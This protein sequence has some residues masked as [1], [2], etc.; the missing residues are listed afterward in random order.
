VCGGAIVEEDAMTRE[1]DIRLRDAVLRQLDWDPEID[2][3]GLAVAAQNG[4]VMLTGYVDSAPG[5]LAAE[6]A[7][8]QVEGVRAVVNQ[9]E[10]RL[11]SE[12]TDADIAKE[13]ARVLRLQGT[14][15]DGVE[16]LVRGGCVTLIGHVAWPFQKADAE[17]AVRHIPGVRAVM[18]HIALV[19]ESEGPATGD[20]PAADG[21][22][23]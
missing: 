9:I 11:R 18:N 7:A 6:H 19:P 17:Q 23:D 3:S 12:W 10:V 2:A 5:R 21:T 22:N 13:A 1:A 14:V 16:A 15:P 4:I 20:V 8:G